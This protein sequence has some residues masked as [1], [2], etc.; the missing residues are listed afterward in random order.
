MI[1]TN[2]HVGHRGRGFLRPGP[3]VASGSLLPP[4]PC[5][6]LR[7]RKHGDRLSMG[8]ARAIRQLSPLVDLEGIGKLELA[9]VFH[10]FMPDPLFGGTYLLDRLRLYITSTSS[11]SSARR[12]ELAA[13]R[14]PDD[15]PS[16]PKTPVDTLLDQLVQASQRG[17][18]HKV[19]E[20]CNYISTT[21]CKPAKAHQGLNE[22]QQSGNSTLLRNG[23]L[24]LNNSW[25]WRYR[26][27]YLLDIVLFAD[28]VKDDH[29]MTETLTQKLG[30]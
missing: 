3:V 25:K 12:S 23:G 14:P 6:Q 1:I 15:A 5:L 21:L 18:Q 10:R 28:N 24:V 22:Y 2:Y 9:D 27:E 13:F 20:I 11:S 19:K 4:V 7:G 16:Q 17:Q 26:P 30:A 8:D 29:Q